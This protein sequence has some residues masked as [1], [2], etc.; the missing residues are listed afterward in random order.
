MQSLKK[1]N[2]LIFQIAFYSHCGNSCHSVKQRWPSLLCAILNDKGQVCAL[3]SWLCYV[4]WSHMGCWTES[5]LGWCEV[6]LS[7]YYTAASYP[8]GLTLDTAMP[9]AGDWRHLSSSFWYPPLV[10]IH[11]S[12][13]WWG[14]PGT[15][16]V[17][18]T[19]GPRTLVEHYPRLCS[20]HV[21]E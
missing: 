4:F 9:K 16:P 3:D 11:V 6:V 20:S 2:N 8:L 5:F 17:L 21:L 10:D 14:C 15:L 7:G 13:F 12:N 19:A 18:L 1:K